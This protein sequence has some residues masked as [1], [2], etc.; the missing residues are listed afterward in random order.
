MKD[1]LFSF[2][3]AMPELRT[4]TEIIVADVS[5]KDSLAIMCQQGV[6][7]LNCVGPVSTVV[8]ACSDFM[9]GP[10]SLCSP[11]PLSTDFME[12]QWSKL[13]SKMEPTT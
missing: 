7:I 5:I 13:A 3:S 4:D 11:S 1:D 2:P 9:F 6:V 10:I 12:N 8:Q